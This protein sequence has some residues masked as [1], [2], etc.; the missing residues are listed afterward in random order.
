M[1]LAVVKEDIDCSRSSSQKIKEVYAS[2]LAENQQE[3]EYELL[4]V[5]F[6]CTLTHQFF[7]VVVVD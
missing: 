7:V 2:P 3:V 6:F 1:D 4:E 5:N